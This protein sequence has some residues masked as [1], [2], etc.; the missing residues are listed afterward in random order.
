[1]PLLLRQFLGGS[2][3]QLPPNEFKAYLLALAHIYED[4]GPVSDRTM[5]GHLTGK[6]WAKAKLGL[7]DKGRL[8]QVNG[9]Y[10]DR[11]AWAVI[12]DYHAQQDAARNT[13]RKGGLVSA[14]KR[15]EADKRKAAMADLF[16]N[17]LQ[18]GSDTEK[19]NKINEGTQ[20]PVGKRAGARTHAHASKPDANAMHPGCIPVANDL[21]LG[22]D[23]K[24]PNE[25]NGTTQGGLYQREVETEEE[26]TPV[27]P[28]DE[29]AVETVE[30]EV[31]DEDAFTTP[32]R[33]K[34]KRPIPTSWKP[35]RETL[36]DAVREAIA[37]WTDEQFTAEAR[38]FVED[39]KAEDRRHVQWDRAFGNW[40]LK[41]DTWL[42]QRRKH[43]ERP[44][45]WRT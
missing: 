22:S 27:V 18:T 35:D 13:G 6:G 3:P 1:M 38:K 26:R 16:A 36:S 40:C 9:G 7:L 42:Q 14:A 10:M 2:A 39:A 41:H 23:G 32:P 29:N 45:G 8:L 43:H 37:H 5:V 20:G 15:R 44:S 24:N 34:A 30:G 28:L 12:T 33:R 19:P 17:E 31:V 11:Q 21:Q 25:F 4:E